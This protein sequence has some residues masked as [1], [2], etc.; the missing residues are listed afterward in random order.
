MK[1]DD[2]VE[3]YKIKKVIKC[4][5]DGVVVSAADLEKKR[6]VA[7][8]LTPCQKGRTPHV[9]QEILALK[10]L[11]KNLDTRYFA[12]F[13][14]SKEVPGMMAIVMKLVSGVDLAIFLRINGRNRFTEFSLRKT[15]QD[16]FKGTFAR[17]HLFFKG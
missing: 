4:G 17:C 13:S 10:T 9:D 11:N 2:V 6:L 14:E 15:F 8:K 3:G 7:I 1:T 12:Q 5:S 16:V